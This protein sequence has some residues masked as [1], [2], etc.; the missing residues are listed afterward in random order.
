MDGIRYRFG[1]QQGICFDAYTSATRKRNQ[2][3]V[4]EEGGWGR[5][6]KRVNVCI[7]MG[8]KNREGKSARKRHVSY[9]NC[10]LYG[11][12]YSDVDIVLKLFISQMYLSKQSMWYYCEWKKDW[13]KCVANAVF[14]PYIGNN[15]V[16]DFILGFVQ[17]YF[18]SKMTNIL[19]MLA[20]TQNN[21]ANWAQQTFSLN[22]SQSKCRSLKKKWGKCDFSTYAYGS[23]IM[24]HDK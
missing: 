3:G 2:E 10:M 22:S 21:L 11:C 4:E 17:Q 20:K 8:L 5:R 6:K 7:C 14:I 24:S 9:W 16:N 1:R 12:L 18:C 15:T 13:Q 23:K 19:L